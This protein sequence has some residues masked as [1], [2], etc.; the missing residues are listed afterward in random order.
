MKPCPYYSREMVCH[1]KM[2]MDGS[3]EQT[4]GLFRKKFQETDFHIK[5]TDPYSS[6][7]LQAEE[8]IREL[9]RC[10]GRKMVRAGAPKQI[11][12]GALEFEAYMRSNT[13]LN[14]YMLQEEFPETVIL[15]G[16]SDI[17]Q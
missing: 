2:V 17:S 3:K 15:G 6:W 16:T 7:K 4:L 5:Q 14:I 13:A 9:K 1:L 10:A 8:T 12:D 11:W